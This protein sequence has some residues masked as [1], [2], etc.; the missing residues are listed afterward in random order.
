V[1]RPPSPNLG[2]RK[3][4]PSRRRKETPA[5]LRRHQHRLAV[6][7]QVEW[8]IGAPDDV[9]GTGRPGTDFSKVATLT[10]KLRDVENE[11]QVA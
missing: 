11:R 2:S 4:E 10:G 7:R 8:A 3:L 9:A 6:A 5:T 1:S